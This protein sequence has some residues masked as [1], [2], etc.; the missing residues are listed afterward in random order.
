VLR[1]DDFEARGFALC[2]A[3]APSDL[4]ARLE[5]R[6][7]PVPRGGVRRLTSVCP[8]VTELADSPLVRALVG[9]ILGPDALVARSILFDKTPDANWSVPFHQDGAIAVRERIDA[10]GFGPWS[11]K[12]RVHHVQPPAT[13]L[14][15]MVTVRIHIDACDDSNGPL[16]VLPGTHLSG[17]LSDAEIA[18]YKRNTAPVTCEAAPGDAVVMRPLLLHASP[19]A[20]N[21]RHRRVVHL[22]FA[23]DALP[24]GLEWAEA[25]IRAAR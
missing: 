2:R 10:P 18:R 23:A 9:S 5:G 13:V 20:T 22:E 3:L 8:E 12:D 14:A 25:E 21:P 6:L 17:F 24:G 15:R 4:L 7:P 1:L 19:K 16:V 11:V